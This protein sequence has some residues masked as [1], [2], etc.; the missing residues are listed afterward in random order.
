MAVNVLHEGGYLV[1]INVG[2]LNLVNGFIQLFGTNFF[3]GRQSA[4]HKV[5]AYLALNVAHLALFA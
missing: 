4:V 1:F 2:L 3:G 5:F